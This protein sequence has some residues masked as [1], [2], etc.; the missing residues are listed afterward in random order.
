M[1][2]DLDALRRTESAAPVARRSRAGLAVGLVLVT[3][4]LG[5][6]FLLLRPAIFPARVVLTARVR[7]APNS[8]PPNP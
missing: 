6:A 5:W 2:P 1:S 3:G 4:A 8:K 7:V